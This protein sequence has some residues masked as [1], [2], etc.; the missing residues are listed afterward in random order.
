M[1]FTGINEVDTASYR[2]KEL[3]V[4]NTISKYLEW[5]SINDELMIEAIV[6]FLSVC[7]FD[8]ILGIS[9]N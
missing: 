3:A 9:R 1:D 5:R 7:L 8:E 6:I 2:Y 4:Q